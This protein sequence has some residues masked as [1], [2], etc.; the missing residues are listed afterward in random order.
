MRRSLYKPRKSKCNAYS[1]H[2]EVVC[3]FV[4]FVFAPGALL[5]V[6]FLFALASGSRLFHGIKPVCSKSVK[7]R[8][9]SCGS[10][11]EKVLT[12]FYGQKTTIDDCYG[13]S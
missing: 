2:M 9:W 8:L 7:K 12:F 1:E 11:E 10:R 6:F 4:C 5:L 13:I 3:F